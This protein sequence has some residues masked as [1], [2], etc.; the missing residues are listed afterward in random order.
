[1]KIVW[2]AYL[3][4]TVYSFLYFSRPWL[5]DSRRWHIGAMS[6]SYAALATLL[7]TVEIHTPTQ[8]IL[9]IATIA[10]GLLGLATYYVR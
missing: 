3:A 1:M 7:A 9:A 2:L 6:A 5:R 10:T 8:Y 4:F